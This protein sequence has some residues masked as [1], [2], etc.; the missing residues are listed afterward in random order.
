VE[1]KGDQVRASAG[2][3]VP[4]DWVIK[5]VLSDFEGLNPITS[6]DAEAQFCYNEHIYETLLYQDWETLDFTPWLCDSLP[7]ISPDHLTYT[8]HLKKNIT[9]SDGHPLT[10]HDAVFTLKVIMNPMV[11]NGAH[12]RNYFNMVKTAEA[13]DDYTFVVH[14]SQP[15]FQADHQIGTMWIEPKHVLDPKGLT[16]EYTFE[17]CANIPKAKKNKAIREFGDWFESSDVSRNPKYLIGSGPYVVKEWITNDRVITE[18][19]MKY[20]NSGTKWGKSYP[21]KMIY[22][23]VSDFNT[24]L[25]ALK[26]GELDLVTGLT[27]GLYTH[28]IDLQKTPQLAKDAFFFPY[29]YYIGWNEE[30]PLFEDKHVRQAMTYFT[31]VKALIDKV[32]LGLARPIFGMTYF[33]RKECHPTLKPYEFNAEK[34]KQLL[35]EAGWTD[36]DGDGVLEKIIGGRKVDFKFSFLVNSGN[37]IRKNVALILSEELRKAGIIADIQ[38][39]EFT[40]YLQNL[41]NHK[42]DAYVGAWSVPTDAPDEYQIWHSSQAE[43]HGS[44]YISYK[45]REVDSVIEKN[46]VEFDENKRMEYMRRFQEILY[47]D[48][49]YTFLWNPK[50]RAAYS[51]R[52]QNVRWYA[53]MPGYDMQS[54]WVPTANQKYAVS[55]N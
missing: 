40:V 9:F 44:N 14:M 28:Q 54:W 46:R 35:K 53:I 27:P 43:G 17:D 12:L 21:D 32:M 5:H 22:K 26:A 6:T 38:P 45:N 4:G 2:E 51:N 52:F 24:A 48:Q 30:N 8:F 18:R 39:L 13:P 10:A 1:K 11:I 33:M 36:S 23:T 50:E 25:S 41:R 49:P 55:K 16:D 31:D 15:Y 29:I 37:E 47:E 42:F 3:P 34:A 19:N 7:N 20:W